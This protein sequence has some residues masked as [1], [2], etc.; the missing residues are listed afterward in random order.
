MAQ[1]I[2]GKYLYQLVIA[3]FVVNFAAILL[4]R[5]DIRLADFSTFYLILSLSALGYIASKWALTRPGAPQATYIK[6][7]QITEA[8]LFSQL[9]VLSL[10]Y[11]N[12][13][14]MMQPFPYVDSLL[15]GMDE[16][17]GINW[18]AYFELIH[19]SPAA[20]QV[21]EWV[22]A[23]MAQAGFIAIYG[24]ILTGHANRARFFIEAFY[25]TALFC[26][27]AGMFFPAMAAVH[28]YVADLSAYPNFDTPP[29]VYHIDVMHHLREHPGPV[30][31][32]PEAMP[33]LVT[34]P[35]FH[36]AG[37]IVLAVAFWR[38]W[39]IIPFGL[40]TLATIA[41]TPVF[42]GHYI[43]DL[44]A[45][46]VVALGVCY[47]LGRQP[48]YREIFAPRGADATPTGTPVQP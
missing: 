13:L 44:I 31:M 10:Q 33:G 32:N 45:G 48:R 7:S 37:C 17:I 43:I 21:L 34:F 42:G 5:A 18:L 28:E 36:T 47:I 41:S 3:V 26:V 12:H 40:F 30:V 20:I 4:S 15:S 22:Y 6:I 24:L 2:C 46:T 39:A 23:S 16:A 29:G 19:S 11:L 1:P 25:I 27:I 9:S 8:M 35:S 14:S 38:M